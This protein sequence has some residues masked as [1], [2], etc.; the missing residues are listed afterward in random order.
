METKIIT[1]KGKRKVNQDFVFQQE[2]GKDK[3]L[4]LIAD[5]MGGYM[6]G[7]IAAKIVAESISAYLSTVKDIGSKDIQMAVNKA[8][9]AIR[10]RRD[11][12]HEKM[13]A[14]VAGIIVTDNTAICFWVG[15]VK[16]CHFNNWELQFESVDHTLLNSIKSTGSIED[17]S[18]ADKYKHVVTRSIQGNIKHSVID[19]FEFG[20][21]DKGDNILIC[22]DGVHD[23]I[24]GLQ[25]QLML[26]AIKNTTNFVNE[27]E[28]RLK[29]EANDNYSLI[30]I[31]MIL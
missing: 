27:I 2:L 22:S 7:E 16:I 21:I 25:I 4:Y 15:D 17:L 13:G 29:N 23:I 11:D 10:Q 6:H 26:K 12:L 14:T 5:G 8:N 9:L 31:S 1:A 28:L 18:Q 3:Y 20:Q 24:D 30:F 19:Y